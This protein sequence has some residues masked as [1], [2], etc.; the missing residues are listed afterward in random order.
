MR[1]TRRHTTRT[2][3]RNARACGGADCRL[4]HQEPTSHELGMSDKVC[5]VPFPVAVKLHSFFVLVT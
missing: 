2:V 1:K 5:L 4:E 3:G